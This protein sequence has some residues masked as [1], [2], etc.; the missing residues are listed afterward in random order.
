MLPLEPHDSVLP[1]DP[2]LYIPLDPEHPLDAARM[3]SSVADLS[4]D[5]GEKL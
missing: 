2:E 3:R 1:V 4:R 5:Y